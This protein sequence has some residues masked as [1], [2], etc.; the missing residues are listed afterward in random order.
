MSSAYT[1]GGVSPVPA[2]AGKFQGY[3]QDRRVVGVRPYPPKSPPFSFLTRFR[4]STTPSSNLPYFVTR[5]SLL[6]SLSKLLL[7][8]ATIPLEFWP[9][10][11]IGFSS[12]LAPARSILPSKP[13]LMRNSS[14][15]RS[16]NG[17]ISSLSC[18][19]TCE[20]SLPPVFPHSFLTRLPSLSSEVRGETIV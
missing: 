10:T 5:S 6:L 3:I 12:S 8:L 11:M 20:P 4:S 18:V 15:L 9:E 7:L 13:S 19:P 14:N 1:P 2:S 17:A 16:Q